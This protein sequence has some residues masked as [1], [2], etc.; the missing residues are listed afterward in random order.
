DDRSAPSRAEDVEIVLGGRR[1]VLTVLAAGLGL[2]VGFDVGLGVD[3]D[4]VGDRLG[5]VGVDEDRVTV[6]EQELAPLDQIVEGDPA[7]VRAQPHGIAAGH[8][9]DASGHVIGA[10][11]VL[12]VGGRA[13]PRPVGAGSDAHG[14]GRTPGA[15]IGDGRGPAVEVDLHETVGSGDQHT[16]R[17]ATGLLYDGAVADIDRHRIELR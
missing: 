14:P 17:F 2:V 16:G 9:L 12:Q 3:L 7:V 1:A 8:A 10:V 15:V 11:A 13:S 5:P 6:A 4:L